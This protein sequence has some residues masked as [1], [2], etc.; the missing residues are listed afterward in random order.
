MN[1]TK[2]KA[3]NGQR[4]T[5][6]QRALLSTR[7]TNFGTKFKGKNSAQESKGKKKAPENKKRFAQEFE[8]HK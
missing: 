1:Y 5:L 4:T 7:I 3:F 6:T 8:F 2:N